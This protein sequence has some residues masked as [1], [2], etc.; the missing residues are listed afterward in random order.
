M[1]QESDT[2]TFDTIEA[3]APPIQ[4]KT[5][6]KIE[7]NKI[8]TDSSSSQKKNFLSAPT[9]YMTDEKADKLKQYEPTDVAKLKERKHSDFTKPLN[10]KSLSNSQNSQH[11]SSDEPVP[12]KQPQI[13]VRDSI[14]K[15]DI[16][17]IDENEKLD[18][19]SEIPTVIHNDEDQKQM[20][21]ASTEKKG[22]T[23]SSA[24]LVDNK[25]SEE[26]EVVDIARNEISSTPFSSQ[27]IKSTPEFTIGIKSRGLEKKQRFT[28]VSELNNSKTKKNLA[29]EE[30]D[31]RELSYISSLIKEDD[32]SHLESIIEEETKKSP[33]T[34]KKEIMSQ[35]VSWMSQRLKS[36][37]KNANETSEIKSGSQKRDTQYTS[38]DELKQNEEPK[39]IIEKDEAVPVKYEESSAASLEVVES[40]A[41]LTKGKKKEE[42]KKVVKMEETSEVLGQEG[43]DIKDGETIREKRVK[44]KESKNQ[45]RKKIIQEIK[46]TIN[47]LDK[48]VSA[49]SVKKE[50]IEQETKNKITLQM[51]QK[52]PSL[53]SLNSSQLLKNSTNQSGEK[54]MEEIVDKEAM[55]KSLNQLDNLLS[56]QIDDVAG[57]EDLVAMP[58]PEDEQE[59]I[60]KELSK[61]I[62]KEKEKKPK[63]KEDNKEKGKKKGILEREKELMKDN[64]N[65]T[66]KGLSGTKQMRKSLLKKDEPEEKKTI[67]KAMKEIKNEVLGKKEKKIKE[68]MT[69]EIDKE[70]PVKD[71]IKL[72][73]GNENNNGLSGISDIVG[74]QPVK[75][76]PE[77]E[78]KPIDKWKKTTT[79][80][81]SEPKEKKGRKSS[82]AESEKKF[83]TQEDTSTS[84][85]KS[86]F[87]PYNPSQTQKE[88]HTQ[89]GR[90]EKK[91]KIITEENQPKYQQLLNIIKA[92]SEPGEEFFDIEN[93]KRNEKIIVVQGKTEETFVDQYQSGRRVLRYQNIKG[94]KRTYP[95]WRRV[96]YYDYSWGMTINDFPELKREEEQWEE[97]FYDE[98]GY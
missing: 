83:K 10:P 82:K 38:S 87:S 27:N 86:T 56:S 39:K 3:V 60:V 21:I 45:E 63:L 76:T 51:S 55:R 44:E 14:L 32:K 54:K 28:R 50:E 57:A 19:I 23:T 88:K 65:K 35:K 93:D 34:N 13:I 74:S 81:I 78:E 71:E 61:E 36:Q 70:K 9:L 96:N 5:L 25:G 69:N 2:T 11:T 17:L 46:D 85:L 75:S 49:I 26:M 84:K 40:L 62:D 72:K 41:A 37:K 42:P 20:D 94:R 92:S 80:E 6:E 89:K 29:Q 59:E 48:K 79:Q 97:Q 12:L 73:E 68:K 95:I 7:V 33:E 8:S 90:K 58:L 31:E 53:G 52:V 18:S 24:P 64:E 22:K 66:K 98:Q 4:I 77:W 30:Y 47:I 43:K 15:K 91:V 67:S 1:S 16:Q